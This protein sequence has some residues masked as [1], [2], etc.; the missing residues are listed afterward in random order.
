MLGAVIGI[1]TANETAKDPHFY[2]NLV[3]SSGWVT[4]IDLET[5]GRTLPIQK[6]LVDYDK[7]PMRCKACHSWK[8]RVRD[9]LEVQ[10]TS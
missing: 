8:H 5:E 10:K 1:D 7:L 3:V 4:S 6:I 2:I 9:C